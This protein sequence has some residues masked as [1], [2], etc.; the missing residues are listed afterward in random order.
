MQLVPVFYASLDTHL[1]FVGGMFCSSPEKTSL[2]ELHLCIPL[3][4]SNLGVPILHSCARLLFCMVI[5]RVRQ[6][7]RSES[8]KKESLRGFVSTSQLWFC[9]NYCWHTC[10]QMC[11]CFCNLKGSLKHC[12]K[13]I[14]LLSLTDDDFACCCLVAVQPNC[15]P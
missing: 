3:W 1:S 10:N 7:S 12:F 5:T 14:I 6:L 2:T 4:L 9:H 15:F 13:Y 8:A 11:F